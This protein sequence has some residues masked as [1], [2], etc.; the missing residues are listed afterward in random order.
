MIAPH[1]EKEGG[2][3]QYVKAWV[4]CSKC[5][6]ARHRVLPGQKTPHWYCQD[7][8][9]ELKPNQEIEVEYLDDKGTD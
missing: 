8:R 5:N 3:I 2:E 4:V 6:N 1:V 7:E 9:C